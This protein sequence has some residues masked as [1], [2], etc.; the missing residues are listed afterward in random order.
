MIIKKIASKKA[1]KQIAQLLIVSMA[2]SLTACVTTNGDGSKVTEVETPDRKK[3]DIYAE[4]A[5]GYIKKKQY[6]IAERE[7]RKAI[8]IVPD[9]SVSNY[10]MGLLMIETEQ[11]DRVEPFME[12]A[13]NSD[14]S[15]SSAAHDFG[16]FLCQR[17]QELRS[18]VYFDKAASNPYFERPELSMMRAGECLY[19]VGDVIRAETYLKKSLQL[20]PQMRPALFNLAKIKYQ[21][22]S[23]LSARAYIERYFAITKPQAASLLLGYQIESKLNARDVAEKY[24]VMLLENFPGSREA[25]DLRSRVN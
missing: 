21:T 4:L 2:L 16:V 18:V 23:Y 22:K 1:L 11:Y 15:N 24:R 19:K 7:L 14:N 12:K 5:R 8:Q 3:A 10:M 25:R 9:H 20:N 13:V 17:G 6:Q